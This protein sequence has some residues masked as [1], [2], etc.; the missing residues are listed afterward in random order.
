MVEDQ[1]QKIT[2]ETIKQHLIKQFQPKISFCV[3]IIIICIVFSLITNAV[4][5]FDW[6]V[7][8]AWYVPASFV[9][10]LA[11]NYIIFFNVVI[12]RGN[13]HVTKDTL[14]DYKRDVVRWYPFIHIFRFTLGYNFV[15]KKIGLIFIPQRSVSYFN[16]DDTFYIVRSDFG[17]HRV[18]RVY[19]A[20]SYNYNDK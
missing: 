6:E 17:K 2:D 1:K 12:K 10:S 8:F 11:L 20:G 4:I 15:F 13:F 16:K 3:F 7:F 5:G 9:F 14:I 19:N 18:L